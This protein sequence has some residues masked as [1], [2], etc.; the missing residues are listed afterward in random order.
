MTHRRKEIR[1]RAVAVLAAADIVADGRVVSN[2]LIAA[3]EDNLPMINVLSADE[4]EQIQEVSGAGLIRTLQLAI[5]ITA[6]TADGETI[7]DAL[8][9]LAEDVEDAMEGDPTLSQL[10]IDCTLAS[11]AIATD[12]SGHYSLGRIRLTYQTRYRY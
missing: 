11:T 5:E 2:R 4:A 8:D 10:A 7:D 6:K 9:A 3:H 1:D 12:V